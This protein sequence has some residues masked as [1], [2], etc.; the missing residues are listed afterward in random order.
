MKIECTGPRR[1]AEREVGRTATVL[2]CRGGPLPT[3][4]SGTQVRFHLPGV[5]GKARTADTLGMWDE[6]NKEI[7]NDSKVMNGNLFCRFSLVMRKAP[8]VARST[9]VAAL[10]CVLSNP[11][12]P[13]AFLIEATGC[14][15][16]GVSRPFL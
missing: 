3:S 2:G 11:G 10:G 5:A 7:K 14:L 16:A 12:L 9:V 8:A 1:V 4:R 6:K 13:R 15:G